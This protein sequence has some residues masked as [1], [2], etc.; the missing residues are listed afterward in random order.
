MENR[1]LNFKFNHLRRHRAKKDGL[2][3]PT[4]MVNASTKIPPLQNANTNLVEKV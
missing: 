1:E 3:T 4:K 2:P